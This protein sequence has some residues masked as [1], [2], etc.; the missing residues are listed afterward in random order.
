MET[1]YLKTGVLYYEKD[2]CNYGYTLIAPVFSTKTYLIDMEG[3]PVHEWECKIQAGMHAELLPNG[4]LLRSGRLPDSPVAFGG[5]GG[6]IQEF[7]WQG[8]IVWEYKL[9]SDHAVHHHTFKRLPN[10]NTM[11]LGWEYKSYEECLAKGRR[12][13]TILKEGVLEEDIVHY[14]IW[15]DFLVEVNKQNETV[16]EWHAWDH[17]GTGKNQLDI[18]Y[19]L[20]L[21]LQTYGSA[22]WTHC[23]AIDFDEKNNIVLLNSRNFSEFYF[24]DYKTGE[25]RYR[26]GN[27]TTHTNAKKPSFGDD[28]D[29]TL[30]GP[31]NAHFLPNGNIL[32]FDNGW[33]RPQGNRSRIVEMNPQTNKIVWEYISQNPNGF[34]SPYQGSCQRLENGNTLIC[35][36]NAGQIFELTPKGK[37]VWI[38]IAPYAAN[39]EYKEFLH[40]NTDV[41]PKGQNRNLGSQFN[42][43]HRAYRYSYEY[44]KNASFPLLQKLTDNI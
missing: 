8:N 38:Y 15:P 33:L 29:Q 37:A 18:N 41:N 10:G 27:K 12:P 2:R 36:S 40:D 13:E 6:I 23:N 16:W 19:H 26:W 31:H 20:P 30:F 14:G 35:S 1:L 34:S 9:K 21:C 43:V 3:N 32:I 7:D 39:G 24:I 28:G 5:H 4:N 44:L 17:L 42:M 11:L 22:D 25:I